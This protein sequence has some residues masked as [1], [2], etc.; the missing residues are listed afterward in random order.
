MNYTCATVKE[1]KANKIQNL[2]PR[3]GYIHGSLTGYVPG[4]DGVWRGGGHLP[5]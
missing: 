1:G 3:M 5:R 2:H 4:T